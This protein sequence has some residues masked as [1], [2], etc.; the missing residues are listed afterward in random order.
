MGADELAQAAMDH[1]QNIQQV[2][3]DRVF[4]IVAEVAHQVRN[5]AKGVIDVPAPPSK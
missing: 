4:L 3:V 2:G 1:G 5:G